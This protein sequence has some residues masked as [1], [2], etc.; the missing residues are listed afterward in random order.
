MVL[1]LPRWFQDDTGASQDGPSASKMIKLYWQ[2]QV[3]TVTVQDCQVSTDSVQVGT[4]GAN[5]VQDGD[6]VVQDGDNVVQD[7]DNIVQDYSGAV[8]DGQYAQLV[9]DVQDV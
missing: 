5:I 9:Q 8:Q 2:C 7:G 3:G 6:N 1:V 4:G